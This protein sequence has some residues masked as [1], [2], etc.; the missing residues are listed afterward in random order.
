MHHTEL[1]SVTDPYL[2]KI[3]RYIIWLGFMVSLAGLAACGESKG[4][5]TSDFPTPEAEPCGDGCEDGFSCVPGID[6][7]GDPAFLCINVHIRF[8]APCME[9]ADCIDPL[10]PD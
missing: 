5:G 9:D 10:M 2:S 3:T 7:N 4:L 6:E 8:C 1:S